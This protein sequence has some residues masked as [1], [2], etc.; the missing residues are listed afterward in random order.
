MHT[1]SL[2]S[3]W[4]EQLLPLGALAL[5][6]LTGIGAASAR[7]ETLQF[8]THIVDAEP[9]IAD[10][11]TGGPAGWAASDG[12]DLRLDGGTL[13]LSGDGAALNVVW[14]FIVAPLIGGGLAAACWKA[15]DTP[16]LTA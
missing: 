5:L 2:T 11:L 13:A 10:A 3:G 14:V 4:L 9:L 16:Q 15:L 6:C 8:D 7:A 1:V 12:A